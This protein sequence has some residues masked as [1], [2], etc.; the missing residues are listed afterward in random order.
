ML[1][2][3]RG[4]KKKSGTYTDFRKAPDGAFFIR[5]HARGHKR[6]TNDIFVSPLASLTGDDIQHLCDVA[7]EEGPRLEFK[8][9]LST[10]DGRTP[11]RWMKD[12]SGIG[13]AARDDIARRLWLLQ[14][15]TAECW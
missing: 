1:N 11:D 2:P 10:S 9:A 12:Q 5:G 15:L 3:A 13:T 7:A 8:R 6:M 4:A 14:M